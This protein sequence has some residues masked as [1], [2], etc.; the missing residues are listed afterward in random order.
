M[1]VRMN[2]AWD[3]GT[4]KL[5]PGDEY[6]DF[7]HS[8]QARLIKSG[9][10]T[11]LSLNEA[12]AAAGMAA[13]PHIEDR[14]SMNMTKAELIEMAEELGIE[15]ETDDNKSELIDKIERALEQ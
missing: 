12:R 3:D 7:P 15:Y 5:S 10:A 9:L 6:Y 2:V 13:L 4:V 1:G 8:L 11:Q 14:P